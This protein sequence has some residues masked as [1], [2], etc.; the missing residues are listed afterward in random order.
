MKKQLYM[1]VT[2][3]ALITVAGLS[4]AK[5]QTQA[6][7]QLKANIPFAFSVGNKTLP[8]G[9]YTVRCTNPSSDM[10]VLQLRSIDGR[11]S[12]LVRTNSVNGKIQDNAK[13]VFYRYADQYFFAQVWLPSEA[14]GMQAAK[15]RAEKQMAR[16]LAANK[17]AKETVAVTAKR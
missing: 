13:L 5:A 2:I 3:I 8:A 14:I 12:A 4:S 17:S 7:V 1:L 15:S 9:E 10:K 6:S 11:E 16:E